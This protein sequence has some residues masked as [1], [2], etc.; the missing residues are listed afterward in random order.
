MDF[1]LVPSP[2]KRVVWWARYGGVAAW[3]SC[4]QAT[5]PSCSRP[6]AWRVGGRVFTMREPFTH[7]AL[8]GGGRDAHSASAK[9]TLAYVEAIR[10]DDARLHDEQSGGWCLSSA[11]RRLFREVDVKPPIG[12]HLDI[13]SAA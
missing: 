10:P 4:A 2:R 12:A 5:S 11:A 6:K 9:L 8:R 13:T 7:G 1:L 3:S